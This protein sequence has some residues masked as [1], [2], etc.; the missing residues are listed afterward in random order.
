MPGHHQ[1]CCPVEWNDPDQPVPEE[2]SRPHRRLGNGP[3]DEARDDEEYVN[4]C[5]AE[6]RS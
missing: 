6:E 3:H 1:S 2:G 5:I 4:A